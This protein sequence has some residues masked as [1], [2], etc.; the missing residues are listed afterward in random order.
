MKK[1]I[2]LLA[3]VLIAFAA[4]LLADQIA[5]A[6]LT[7]NDSTAGTLLNSDGLGTY[8][9]RR[10]NN[11]NICVTA[12]VNASGLFFIYMDYNPAIGT[13]GNCDS[14]LGIQG[15]TYFLAFPAATGICLALSLPVDPSG[16]CGL[17]TEANPRIRADNLF[18]S[19]ASTT[20]AAFMFLWNGNSYSL[21][22]NNAASVSGTGDTRT[23][24]Y[25]G[26]ATLWQ[27]FSAPQKPKQI[28]SSF[29]FPF[30]FTVQ[31]F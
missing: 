25:G 6:E 28:G 11:G 17:K 26:N 19:G 13:P 12:W 16:N 14:T 4:G 15:R 29:S 1:T 7:I 9:D 21:Q 31:H 10:L 2:M 18:S 30:Q 27:I 3:S 22:T 24:T 8:L 23:A 5:P 20:P